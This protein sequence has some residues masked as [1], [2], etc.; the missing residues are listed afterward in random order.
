MQPFGPFV[1]QHHMVRTSEQGSYCAAGAMSAALASVHRVCRTEEQ[2]C[3]GWALEGR[4]GDLCEH[5]EC[6]EASKREI[7]QPRPLNQP[8]LHVRA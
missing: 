1:R 5:C 2:A 6:L 8:L 4:L 3:V 7:E